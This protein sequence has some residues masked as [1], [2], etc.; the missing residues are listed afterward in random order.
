MVSCSHMHLHCV[1]SHSHTHFTGTSGEASNTDW[2]IVISLPSSEASI[3]CQ[4][5]SV[6]CRAVV[7]R[8][9]NGSIHLVPP[10]MAWVPL[11]EPTWQERIHS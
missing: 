5:L 3:K 7:K 8:W 2:N 10:L 1:N 9:L 11:P 6:S 4:A